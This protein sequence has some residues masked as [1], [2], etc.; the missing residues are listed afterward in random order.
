[1]TDKQR[2]VLSLMLSVLALLV[3]GVIV[4]IELLS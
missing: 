4:S 1:M 3:S 2:L